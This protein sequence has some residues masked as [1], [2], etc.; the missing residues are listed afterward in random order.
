MD[1]EFPTKTGQEVRIIRQ[2]PDD[3]FYRACPKCAHELDMATGEWVPDWPKRSIHG[4]RISQLFSPMVDPGE[5]MQ[6]YRTTRFPDRF[7][8]LKIGIPWADLG[9]R[10]DT[11]SVIGLCRDVPMAENAPWDSDCLMGVDTGKDLHVVVL[12]DDRDGERDPIRLIHLQVCHEFSELD[13][14]MERFDIYRCVIDGLPETHSTR[15]FAKRHWGHVYLNF[16][17]ENQRG[18][19]NWGTRSKI[20][21]INRTEALDASR[22]AVR[23]KMVVLPRRSPLVEE[24]AMHMTCDAKVLEEDEETGVKKYRYIRTGTNHFSMAFTYAWIAANRRRRGPFVPWA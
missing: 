16:F 17:N 21:Q 1:K 10:P 7:Y 18:S 3:T 23:E 24:F 9:R 12:W 13:R 19:A 5:I 8:N 14:L 4:Y 2:R 20:V 15:E 6:E 11:S 22:T